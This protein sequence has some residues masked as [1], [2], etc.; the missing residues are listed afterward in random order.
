MANKVSIKKI[1]LARSILKEAEKAD[2][3]EKKTKIRKLNL[4]LKE[5]EK[6]SKLPD[7]E[8]EL[9][10]LNKEQEDFNK[11]VQEKNAKF[12]EQRKAILDKIEQR[13]LIENGRIQKIKTTISEIEQLLPQPESITD[14]VT[15]QAAV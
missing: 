13:R 9:T 10:D 14:K 8:K 7:L 1:R 4:K 15:Q 3:A 5:V 6:E 2:V 12:D 11:S